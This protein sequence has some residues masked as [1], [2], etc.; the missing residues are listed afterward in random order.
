M[1]TTTK[2]SIYST[3]YIDYINFVK[4][5]TTQG[6]TLLR[7]AESMER[8]YGFELAV[9]RREDILSSPE[10]TAKRPDVPPTVGEILYPDLSWE[11]LQEYNR[12]MMFCYLFYLISHDE[13]ELFTACQPEKVKLS[14][15]HFNEIVALTESVLEDSEGYENYVNILMMSDLLM[16]DASL[17]DIGKVRG[18]AEMYNRLVGKSGS[19]IADHDE[20]LMYAL[21]KYPQEISKAYFRMSREQQNHLKQVLRIK[22][23]LGQLP[24][25][26]NL[27]GNMTELVNIE[28]KILNFWI[29]KSLLD[30]AGAAGAATQNGSV[31]CNEL[32]YRGFKIAIEAI[33]MLI[34]GE[35]P[36][37]VYD[38][39]LNERAK[40]MHT[41]ISTDMNYAKARLALMNRMFSPSDYQQLSQAFD[42]CDLE[43]R[44]ILI[45]Y[46][47]SVGMHDFDVHKDNCSFQK[48]KMGPGIL[49]YY[50]P[51]YFD[52][53]KKSEHGKVMGLKES[54]LWLLPPYANALQEMARY[55]YTTKSKNGIFAGKVHVLNLEALAKAAKLTPDKLN[56]LEFQ[57]DTMGGGDDAI[58][59]VKK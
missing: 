1:L 18:I 3:G 13:Y 19:A 42:E 47:N 16:A 27:A 22:Y 53:F 33:R 24:Q 41:D 8:V 39:H 36:Q 43:T 34:A 17:H 12:T 58:L 46:L 51:A 28:G 45:T 14:R 6:L 2:K 9:L 52:N 56:S 25:G 50:S 15:S 32:F 44:D 57:L 26:E 40:L 31:V 37:V 35:S 10:G 4:N 11:R 23:N 59:L 48:N 5:L 38:W 55:L 30:I 20:P 49:P 29:L 21:E 7:F 54:L